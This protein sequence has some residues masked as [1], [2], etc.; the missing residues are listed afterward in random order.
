MHLQRGRNGL[1]LEY[2]NHVQF[3][4]KC[5]GPTTLCKRDGRPPVYIICDVIS[6][7]VQFRRLGRAFS[8]SYRADKHVLARRNWR[9]NQLNAFADLVRNI[10]DI[11]FMWPSKNLEGCIV[12]DPRVGSLFRSVDLRVPRRLAGPSL[13]RG[14][15]RKTCSACRDTE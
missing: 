1:N 2:S 10:M 14:L 4:R 5:M 12:R 6:E 9:S 13:W 7:Y 15:R 3:S 11:G 8:Q